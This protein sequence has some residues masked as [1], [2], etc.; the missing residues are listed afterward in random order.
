MGKYYIY[1]ISDS[2][3]ETGEHVA[4]AAAGQFKNSEF[5]VKKYPYIEDVERI[6]EIL[7][8]AATRRSILVFTTVLQHLREMITGFCKAHKMPF[9]DVMNPLIHTFKH[10][11]NEDPINEPGTIHKLDEK[12]FNRVEAVEFAVKYDD[13]K[14]PRGVKK[15][16]VVILGISRTS[17]TPLS[18]YLAHKNIK[19]ANIPLVP[20]VPVPK[21]V[22]EISSKKIVGLTNTPAKLNE[23]REERLKALG[24]TSNAIYANMNRINE[25]LEYAEEIMSAIGCPVIDVSNKAIEET[26]NIIL[27]ILME[28]K[29]D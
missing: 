9:I 6:K 27:Q 8:E 22:Y 26:A 5:E 21:E 16:D 1:I 25:E 7:E 24:L 19:V 20:E 28:Q 29:Q 3:G 23:I 13:G 12:Y 15:A 10:F 2:V 17:K 11:L 14:D 4:R 18:M